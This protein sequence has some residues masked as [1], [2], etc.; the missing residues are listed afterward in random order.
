MKRN[1]AIRTVL[2]LLLAAALAVP[3]GALRMDD[4]AL[5][6]AAETAPGEEFRI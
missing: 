2:C 4:P 1:H 6:T 3:A 5:L